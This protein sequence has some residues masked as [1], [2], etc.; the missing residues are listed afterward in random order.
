[1]S[2]KL[3][4]KVQHVP[5]VIVKADDIQAEAGIFV[6]INRVRKNVTGL[7]LFFAQL[8]ADD[9]RAVAILNLC[10]QAGIRIPKHPGDYKPGDS[11]AVGALAAI[12]AGYAE[13]RALRILA[14]AAAGKFKPITAAHIKAVEHL[15]NDPEFRDQIVAEDLAAMLER[16]GNMH[17]GEA[18]RFAATHK[19]S[20]WK[21]LASVW[22][23]KTRKRRAPAQT[24]I[25]S[26]PVPERFR[27]FVPHTV[28]TQRNVTAVVAGD[29][30]PGRSALDQKRA[31]SA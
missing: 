19:V 18:K 22:F 16:D 8:A 26:E 1:M 30:P 27:T 29:P 28:A 11:V 3:H 5:V 24:G 14:T 6:D 13:E 23:Q 4:P 25:R 10:K 12:E 2:D 17:D 15:L 21:G 20:T 31:A 7:E 9:P